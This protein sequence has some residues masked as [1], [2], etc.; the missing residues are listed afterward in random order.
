MKIMRPLIQ[1]WSGNV[2]I[3]LLILLIQ[4]IKI[5]NILKHLKIYE[6]GADKKQDNSNWIC[7]RRELVLFLLELS[8]Q[9]LEEAKR[10]TI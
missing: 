1:N 3:P 8:A 2:F 6:I 7:G 9:N 10:P 5:K 4:S